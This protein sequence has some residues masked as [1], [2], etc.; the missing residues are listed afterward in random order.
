M[1]AAVLVIVLMLVLAPAGYVRREWVRPGA[2]SVLV[3]GSR[4]RCLAGKAR[5]RARAAARKAA[6]S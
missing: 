2:A 5:R 3:E 4:D 1:R 6:K